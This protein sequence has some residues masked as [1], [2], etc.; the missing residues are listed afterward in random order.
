[1]KNPNLLQEAIIEARELKEAAEKSVKQQLMEELS[2]LIKKTMESHFSSMLK[3]QDSSFSIEEVPTDKLVSADTGLDTDVGTLPVNPIAGGV[4]V[5]DTASEEEKA[6]DVANPIAADEHSV[7]IPLPDAS[8]MI[9]VS[10]EDLFTKPNG[11]IQALDSFVAPNAVAPEVV[12]TVP[13]PVPAS[14]DLQAAA[15]DPSAT[16]LAEG[17]K[18]KFLK[19]VEYFVEKEKSITSM[20]PTLAEN[21]QLGLI[22]LQ[23]EGQDLLEKGMIE[24]RD[25]VL[26]K[27]RAEKIQNSVHEKL[28]SA[29]EQNSYNVESNQKTDGE[30]MAIRKT[31]KD[32][33][34]ETEVTFDGLDTEKAKKEADAKQNKLNGQD[35]G[36]NPGDKDV[37]GKS[38]EGDWGTEGA[39]GAASDSVAQKAALEEAIALFHAAMSLNEDDEVSVLDGSTGS[40]DAGS[41]APAEG[42]SADAGSGEGFDIEALLRDFEKQLED[43]GISLDSLDVDVAGEKDGSEFDL[44]FDLDPEG[45][46]EPA[47][48]EG[49][50]PFGGAGEGD[51]G[52]DALVIAEALQTIKKAKTMIQEARA[53]KT[54]LELYN[55]KTISLNKLLLKEAIV[56]TAEKKAA[57]VALDK[58]NTLKEVQEIYNRIVAHKQQNDKAARSGMAT[59]GTENST[60]SESAKVDA[61]TNLNESADPFVTRMQ[62]LAKM[63]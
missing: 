31:L 57:V 63:K 2:P 62:S 3:E 54:E 34:E 58:G 53:E 43:H 5:T 40:S 27:K 13:T 46:V 20:T 18:G 21:I 15:T 51:S 38:K 42:S 50:S 48:P 44:K 26:C 11:V 52:A 30:N 61:A 1:M 25:L 49:S 10:I 47:K 29:L 37:D 7:N 36:Q 16:A 9:T 24:A 12:E 33:F 35:P 17:A 41:D 60:I 59:A 32:L 8:G 45:N 39:K 19:L 23:E 6:T 14:D 56:T 28:N 4:E 22:A 55:F